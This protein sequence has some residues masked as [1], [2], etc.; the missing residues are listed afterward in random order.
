MPA[1]IIQMMAFTQ[2]MAIWTPAFLVLNGLVLLVLEGQHYNW[3]FTIFMSFLVVV[4]CLI[5]CIYFISSCFDILES[6]F[7]LFFTEIVGLENAPA[8]IP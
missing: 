6:L 5:K 3:L 7:L 2:I 4:L 8:C 1:Q